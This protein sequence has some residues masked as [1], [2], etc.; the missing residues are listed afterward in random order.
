MGLPI[1][2][3]FMGGELRL[4]QGQTTFLFRMQAGDLKV[5]LILQIDVSLP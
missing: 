5:Y 4:M 3:S 2:S 1:F